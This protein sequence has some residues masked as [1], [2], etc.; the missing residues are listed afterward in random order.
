MV[1][2]RT[3]LGRVGA[4]AIIAGLIG[5]AWLS[6]LFET[7]R[8]EK[9]E[10]PLAGLPSE[11]QPGPFPHEA[12]DSVLKRVVDLHGRVDYR[13]LTEDRS[14]LERYLFAL[15]TVSP[16]SAPGAFATEQD[17]LAY[18][19]NAYNA[20]VL[21]GVTERPGLTSVRDRRADFFAL[22]R[23]VFGDEPLSLHTLETSVIRAELKEPRI[24]VALNCASVGCPRLPAEAFDPAQLEQQLTRE[25][26][27]F[28]ADEANVRISG[29]RIE[30]SQ[31]FQW[32]RDDFEAGGG[33]LAFCRRWGRNDL[34]ADAPIDFIPYDWSL[35][36]Q[37]GRHPPLR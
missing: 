37:P 21:F 23:Y 30:L 10:Y 24:H 2:V 19:L 13:A 33:P 7:V 31:I 11:S 6:T 8:V 3:W 15:A 27:A 5:L 17:R 4:L 25:A 34:P 9:P 16:R 20:A 12:F 14:D 29:N 1:S 22:T 36:A 35:N 26:R 28:C 18:W 32:Y